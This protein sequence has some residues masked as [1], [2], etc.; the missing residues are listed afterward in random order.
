[1]LYLQIGGKEYFDDEKEEFITLGTRQVRF[2][3]CLR[4]IAEWES[5]YKKPFLTAYP[6]KTDLELRDYFHMMC[7]DSFDDSELTIAN[8]N[9]IIDYMNGEHSAT[10]ILETEQSGGRKIYT[11]EYLYAIMVKAGIPFEA[12]DWNYSR[13]LK[14]ISILGEMSSEPRKMTRQEI[15]EQNRRLNEQRKKELNTKG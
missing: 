10:T 2:E 8:V 12:Q 1:M 13:F 7:L 3:H 14:L 9:S 15:F 11:S 6:P 4:A 5:V